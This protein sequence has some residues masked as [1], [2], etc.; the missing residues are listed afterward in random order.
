[1]TRILLDC[2]DLERTADA[3]LD[4]SGELAGVLAQLPDDALTLM[5]P[6]VAAHVVE[7]VV[8][9]E[10][11]VG[12]VAV[13]IALDAAEL[14]RRALLAELSQ[15]GTLASLG[16]SL[17]FLHDGLGAI[18]GGIETYVFL[19]K[20][21]RLSTLENLSRMAP[22]VLGQTFRWLE[23]IER[24]SWFTLGGRA[25]LGISA[26]LNLKTAF[27]G[28]DG[29]TLLGRSYTMVASGL[30]D[31]AL[32]HPA[33]AG[34]DVLSLGAVRADLAALYDMGGRS[35]SEAQHGY[36]RAVQDHADEARSHQY[37]EF[38]MH[39]ALG[40]AGGYLRGANEGLN[41]WSR[42]ATNGNWGSGVQAISAI[43][44][45]MIDTTYEPV[46][47]VVGDVNHAVGTGVQALGHG[48]NAGVHAVG[49]GFSDATHAIDD[50]IHGLLRSTW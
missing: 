13:R 23:P 41:D 43:E 5:P 9:T 29:E 15:N 17:A 31:A 44:N 25:L 38:G 20:N 1:M 47:H 14:R 37:L 39:V 35:L 18:G 19:I 28:S 30:S 10:T 7:S 21:A 36:E 34:A 46:S 48:I 50:G 27:D 6:A 26:A 22:N 12:E 8:D 24:S 42:E 11:R 33:V 2:A 32:L 16:G 40:T 45:W 4:I 3:L 49:D